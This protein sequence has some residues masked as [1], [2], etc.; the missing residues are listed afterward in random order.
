MIVMAYSF[1]FNE[2]LFPTELLAKVKEVT[3]LAGGKWAMY[4]QLGGKRERIITDFLIGA[5][6]T[7]RAERF[8][9]RDRGFYRSY[10]SSLHI[11]GS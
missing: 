4:R 2:N 1:Y 6:A 8:L 9:T 10:F 5:H 3:F 7:L 11:F